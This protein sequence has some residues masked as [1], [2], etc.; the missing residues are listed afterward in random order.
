VVGLAQFNWQRAYPWRLWFDQHDCVVLTEFSSGGVTI[1]LNECF[2]RPANPKP[3]FP[4]TYV[5]LDRSTSAVFGQNAATPQNAIQATGTWG[6]TADADPAG[7]LAAAVTSATQATITVS[8]GSQ[9]GVGDLLI[10]GY[11]RGTPPY[12]GDTL[13]HAGL[14]APYVGERVLVC[15]RATVTTGLT[16]SGSGCTTAASGDNQLST[17]G[18]GTLN[19][20]EVLLLD[21]EQMLILQVNG[22]V[23]TVQRAWNGT[24]LATHD[25][26]TVY[27]YRLLSVQRGYLGTTAQSSWPE[28]TA[29]YR[30][31]VPSLIRD[32]AI[33]KAVDQVLQ[34]TSGYA[35]IVGA[36]EAAIPASG[37]ALAR[38]WDEARTEYGRKNR[39]RAI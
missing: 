18:A 21:S 36:G 15:D 5:E 34:E 7:T 13:G 30:H 2:L 25:A 12:P 10:I 23:A 35:R 38:K 19:Q 22:S 37:A 29:V 17:T 27:A 32:L 6:F 28:G 14:I 26:A 16:Q 8:D 9:M 3:G 39:T 31:R 1:G 11:G 20:G 33:A 4:Y 24:V